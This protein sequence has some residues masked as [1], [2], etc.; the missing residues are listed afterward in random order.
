MSRS[1]SHAI[2]LELGETV[3]EKLYQFGEGVFIYSRRGNGMIQG[4][5]TARLIKLNRGRFSIWES[6]G[7]ITLWFAGN[8]NTLPDKTRFQALKK[9][10]REINIT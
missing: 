3:P 4:H 7:N 5:G 2:Q 1:E 8:F 6:K 10:A 9:F